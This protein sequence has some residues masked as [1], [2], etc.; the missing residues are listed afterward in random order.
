MRDLIARALS[1]VLAVLAPRRPGLHSA[2]HLAAQVVEPETAP[3]S[4]WMTPW[5]PSLPTRKTAEEIFRDE[6]INALPL[7]QRERSYA[8][9]FATLGIDYDFPTM[10]LGSVIARQR[11]V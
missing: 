5:P 6:R 2:E 10:D 4:M 3:P 11:A 9:A 1:W 8:A 7:L